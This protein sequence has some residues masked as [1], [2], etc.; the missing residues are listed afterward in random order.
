M[1][2]RSMTGFARVRKNTPEYDVTVGVR[3][4]NH[5]GLDIHFRMP[6]EF[7][8]FE[9]ALR[10]AVKKR[11]ARG[12]LQIQVK[13]ATLKEGAPAMV[14]MAL[15]DAYL[16]AFHRAAAVHGIKG[17]PD[18][19]A[20]F[21]IPGM[22]D[23]AE[24][25]PDPAL[26][27]LLVGALDEALTELN[28]FR[29]REGAEIASDMCARTTAILASARQMDAIRSRALPEFQ[30]RL[31]DKLAEILKSTAVDPQRLAQEAA[32]LA[33]RSDISEE[34]TRLKVHSVQLHDL[35]QAGGEIGKKIDFLLQEM[36]RE[37][38]TILSKS[39]GVGEIGLEITDL[40]LSVKAEIEKIREQ[41]LNLE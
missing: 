26:E 4:V 39:T 32:Y 27:S 41:G 17:E 19:N 6:P 10:S 9:P 21:R 29:Q 20:A 25:E 23:T 24:G 1:S 34:L 22:F 11:L 8:A 37:T 3:S 33:E 40:A 36:H 7:D 5:R 30:Q 16:S 38:N 28:Q 15:L 14:N 31:A 2:A 13:Y 35:L 18:L 12:H